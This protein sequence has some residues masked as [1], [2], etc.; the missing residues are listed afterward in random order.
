MT[1]KEYEY[2]TP[3]VDKIYRIQRLELDYNNIY[4]D[5]SVSD[6]TAKEQLTHIAASIIDI[7]DRATIKQFI[8]FG[9]SKLEE[10][11]ENSIKEINSIDSREPDLK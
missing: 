7:M 10:I 11:K 3:Y 9:M 8:A 2:A 5:L 4:D 1:L 6:Y